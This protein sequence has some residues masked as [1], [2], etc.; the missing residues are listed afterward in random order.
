MQTPFFFSA[1]PLKPCLHKRLLFNKGVK[2]P[3]KE[4]CALVVLHMT[5]DSFD[6]AVIICSSI[7]LLLYH[8][9]FWGRHRFSPDSPTVFSTMMLID[10]N[11]A[12]KHS[13]ITDRAS[14]MVCFCS[15]ESFTSHY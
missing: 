13:T 2:S 10:H 11:F 8:L 15:M 4:R 9:F 3:L 7:G 1:I 5:M 12:L 6:A 14:D